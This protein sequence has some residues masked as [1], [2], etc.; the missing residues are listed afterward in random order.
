MAEETYGYTKEDLI[1]RS[2][3]ALGPVEDVLKGLTNFGNHDWPRACVVGSKVKHYQK[4]KKLYTQ[5]P[6]S[7][8]GIKVYNEHLTT[9]NKIEYRSWNPYRSKLAAA[10]LKGLTPTLTPKTHLLYLGAATGTTISHLS[11]ILT[12]GTIYA[13]ENSPLAVNELLKLTANRPNIIPI[14]QDA[15]HPERYTTLV[16]P[17]DYIY[18]DISQRHQADIFT[19]NITRYLKK[20][21]EAIIM[22][23]ARSIDVALKPQQ[24]YTLVTTHLKQQG[25]TIKNIYDLSPYEKDHAAITISP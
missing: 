4:N 19:T 20:Q 23:K 18:Q 1:G 8:K 11:D 15:F 7:R 6:P 22:V 25:L 24:A 2:F 21:G 13:V 12:N 9:H 17:V 14:L 10:L 5:N 3:T 16:P